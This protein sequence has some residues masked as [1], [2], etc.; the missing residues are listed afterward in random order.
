MRKV[1]KNILLSYS[2]SGIRRNNKT[3]AV[4]GSGH[5]S[6]E[7]SPVYVF[8]RRKPISVA[9]NGSVAEMRTTRPRRSVRVTHWQPVRLKDRRMGLFG[10]S[11][12]PIRLP[13]KSRRFLRREPE[14]AWRSLAIFDD[15]CSRRFRRA[16]VHFCAACLDRQSG[17]TP[18]VARGALGMGRE[19]ASVSQ[20]RRRGGS[21]TPGKPP[22]L[23][24]PRLG[25]LGEASSY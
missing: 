16:A 4:E 25:P 8:P 13:A 15:T 6:A 10:I 11:P 2:P 19:G 12:S 7:R 21:V 24:Q 23:N 1:Y 17:A 22:R 3:V 14:Q 5:V 9:G 18:P 20:C